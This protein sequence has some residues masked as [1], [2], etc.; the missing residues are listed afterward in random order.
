MRKNRQTERH[1]TGG[2]NRTWATAVYAW[3]INKSTSN[4]DNN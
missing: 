1:K 2:K 3:A 4:N